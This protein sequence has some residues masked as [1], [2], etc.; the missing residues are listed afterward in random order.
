[1]ATFV[2]AFFIA[3][4]AVGFALAVAFDT[5]PPDFFKPNFAGC[6]FLAM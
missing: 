2:V 5:F 6:T 1:M 3:F 4:L